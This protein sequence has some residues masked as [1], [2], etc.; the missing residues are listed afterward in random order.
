MSAMVRVEITPELLRQ[1]VDRNVHYSPECCTYA[2]FHITERFPDTWRTGC[3]LLE[4]AVENF[5]S[6]PE[7]AFQRA[8]QWG[9]D[10][11]TQI[12]IDS[13][14]LNET[15]R[16]REPYSEQECERVA[17]YITEHLFVSRNGGWSLVSEAL[18]A[19]GHGDREE[20]PSR[21]GLSLGTLAVGAALGAGIMHYTMRG[22]P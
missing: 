10:E 15:E 11:F 18:Q 20:N 13:Y 4:S 21:S 9:H 5:D 19:T 6:D 3:Q 2:A 17:A 16:R 7:F 22:K 12:E 8:T 1:C 14:L